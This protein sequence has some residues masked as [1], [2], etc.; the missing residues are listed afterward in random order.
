MTLSSFIKSKENNLCINLKSLQNNF[1]WDNKIY[2]I[3]RLYSSLWDV[4][5]KYKMPIEQLKE[6]C[7]FVSRVV[8]NIKE[9]NKDRFFVSGSYALIKKKLIYYKKYIVF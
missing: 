8:K 6:I 2:L 5:N 9:N 1:I 7:L 4:V 3:E